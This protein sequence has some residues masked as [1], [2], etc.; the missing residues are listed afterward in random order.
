[1]DLGIDDDF[2]SDESGLADSEMS[3]EEL[4]KFRAFLDDIQ[5]DDFS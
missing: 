3:Q 5:P 1:M 4:E 2:E